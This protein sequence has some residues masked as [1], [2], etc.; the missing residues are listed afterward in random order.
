MINLNKTYIDILYELVDLY[1]D[2]MVI[3]IRDLFNTKYFKKQILNEIKKDKKFN[4]CN[5]KPI[6]WTEKQFEEQ[7]IIINKVYTI[8]ED[9]KEVS[10][11]IFTLALLTKI[12]PIEIESSKRGHNQID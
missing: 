8:R 9:Y 10:E 11:N 4:E 6:F 3:N 1:K 12:N 7:M 5:C 2:P